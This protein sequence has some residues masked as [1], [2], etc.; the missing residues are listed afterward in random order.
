MRGP[1]PSTSLEVPQFTSCSC[2]LHASHW[3]L[4]LLDVLTDEKQHV[5]LAKMTSCQRLQFDWHVDTLF[6]CCLQQILLFQF[7]GVL[8]VLWVLLCPHLP[9]LLL[10]KG[11][12]THW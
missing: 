8:W 11:I 2:G 6:P 12:T 3:A 1:S 4:C 9:I 10:F 7:W 5:P